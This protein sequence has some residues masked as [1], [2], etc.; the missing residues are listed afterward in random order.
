MTPEHIDLVKSS[1]TRLQPRMNEFVN[2]FYVRLF[3]TT[4]E[5]CLL[6]G[7]KIDLQARALAVMLEKIVRLLDSPDTLVPLLADLGT[8]HAGARVKPEHYTLFGD[9]LLWTLD[10][11]LGH[12]FTPGMKRAWEE[13]YAFLADHMR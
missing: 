1:L 3:D 12:E 4:P 13:T 11:I 5:L 6:F 7:G 9:A 10:M 8:R 2:M